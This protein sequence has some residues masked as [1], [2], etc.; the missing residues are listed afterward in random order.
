MPLWGAV[1]MRPPESKCGALGQGMNR[2]EGPGGRAHGAV[3]AEGLRSYLQRPAW[4]GPAA[5][6]GLLALWCMVAVVFAV[7]HVMWRDEVRA[8]SIA[9]YGRTP[10]D[11]LRALH[12]EG[13]P[14]LWYLLL[15][16]AHALAPSPVVLP[17]VAFLVGL[18]SVCLLLFRSSVKL[19]L[20]ALAILSGL[21]ISQYTVSARNYGISVLL[22][23]ILA[24]QYPKR[25][26][27][28]LVLG[29]LLALLANTNVHSCI[30][31]IGYLTFWWLEIG[32]AIASRRPALR[33]N[34]LANAALSAVGVALCFI[35]VFPSSND[36]AEIHLQLGQ[37]ASLLARAVL[38]P[39]G[40][41]FSIIPAD[42]NRNLPFFL[43][44]TV[45]LLLAVAASVRTLSGMA[46]SLV[47][48]VGFSV[49]FL[50]I[51]RGGYRHEGLFLVFLLTLLWLEAS[52]R[53]APWPQDFRLTQRLATILNRGGLG[54]FALVLAFQWGTTVLDTVDLVRGRTNSSV[55]ALAELLKA[56]SLD[57]ATVMADPDFMVEPLPY[58]SANPTYLPREGRFGRVVH[59]IRKADADLSLGALWR[60]ASIVRACTGRP[61]VI[62]LAADIDQNGDVAIT[63]GYNWSFTAT[64]AEAGAFKAGTERLARLRDALSDEKYDVFLLKSDAPGLSSADVQ[65]D[66]CAAW[67]KPQIVG[68]SEQPAV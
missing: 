21:M 58:Y 10:W 35:T 20:T 11:M 40:S 25:V 47:T 60:R 65:R 2:V 34:F 43:A 23:F 24:D 42:F 18:A 52:G 27:K 16:G 57:G 30:I 8:L 53:G 44:K 62:L 12:G 33:R 5:R 59:F 28:G 51:Y 9:L 67:I 48:F 1:L 6:V 61:V 66:R 55:K 39:S 49:F 56:R 4:H 37:A 41:F 64:A 17:V 68:G 63:E 50:F 13:H 7:R 3:V 15:R 45:I 29:A 46:A 31:V 22:M 36:A 26:G 32:A 54:M 14:A 38:V 19:W